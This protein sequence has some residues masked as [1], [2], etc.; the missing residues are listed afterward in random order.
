VAT[1]VAV[2][3][4]PAPE[5]PVITIAAVVAPPQPS[6]A[7]AAASPCAGLDPVATR[8]M[9]SST[10]AVRCGPQGTATSRLS[11]GS[12]DG[13]KAR[14]PFQRP[15][16]ASNP[17]PGTPVSATPPAGYRAVWDDGRINPNRGL[18]R[19]SFVT[20]SKAPLPAA[21]A[22]E[23]P[24]VPATQVSAPANGHRYVQVGTFGDAA[25]AQ[26]AIARLQALG[27]PVGVG[28][29]TRN[30]RAMQ[31]V[32]VGPFATAT[33]LRAALGQARAAGFGDAFTRR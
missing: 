19:G 14:N 5:A 16:P 23:A 25:N 28:Q 3:P 21:R 29:V 32:A 12:A 6:A 7:P 4:A 8:Y 20:Q 11:S 15:V 17:P 10:Y 2:V 33:A 13:S 27:L 1:P 26:T 9:S 30:G 18:P 22:V 24:E 31:V